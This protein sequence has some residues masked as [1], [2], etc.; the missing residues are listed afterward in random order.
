MSQYNQIIAKKFVL[1]LFEYQQERVFFFME[2]PHIH[3]ARGNELVRKSPTIASEWLSIE[4][5][6]RRAEHGEISFG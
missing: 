6:I 2:N 4:V 5:D 1:G 3:L